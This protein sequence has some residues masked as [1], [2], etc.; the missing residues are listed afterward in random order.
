[1]EKNIKKNIY[2]YIYT[3]NW[4]TL[5]YSRN[6]HNMVN[7]LCFSVAHVRLF[8][9]PRTA[10]HQATLSFTI[11]QGLCKLMSIELMMPPNHLILCR[12]LLLLP[13]IFAS[14]R[15]FSS[16]S[17]LWITRP[18]YWSFITS[19]SNKYSELISFRNDWYDLLAASKKKKKQK[20]KF[21][22]LKTP[23]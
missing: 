2:I 17:A 4:I 3:Y 20:R 11:S 14:I 5:L 16:E 6:Y 9:T 1:M 23:F 21:E 12:P 13:S 10:A 22:E 15:V 19:P 18:K 8:E 7:P